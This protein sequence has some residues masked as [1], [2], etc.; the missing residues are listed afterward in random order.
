MCIHSKTLMNV[1][2]GTNRKINSFL[3]ESHR[4]LQTTT[5]SSKLNISKDIVNECVYICNQNFDH[6]NAFHCAALSDDDWLIW[7]FD[8][9]KINTDSISNHIPLFLEVHHV[10]VTRFQNQHFMKCDCNLYHRY[11]Q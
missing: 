8:D 7:N 11:V 4:Q 1:A 3:N 6:R 9:R 2:S 10:R 5:L